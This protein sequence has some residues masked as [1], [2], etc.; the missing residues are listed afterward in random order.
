MSQ[1]YQDLQPD[2][3]EITAGKVAEVADLIRAT[4]GNAGSAKDVK[5]APSDSLFSPETVSVWVNGLW[6]TS[7][8]LSLTTALLAV[9][10]K[11]WIHQYMAVPSGTP[12]DR[13]RIRQLRFMNLQTWHVPVIISLLPVLMHVALGVFF[14]GLIV[15]L[16]S[17]HS[18]ICAIV[19]TIASIG[20]TAY[21]G[22]TILPLFDPDCPYKTPL[23]MYAHALWVT[24]R[25]K[26][27]HAEKNP[28]MHFEYSDQESV[29]SPTASL[30]DIE[31]AKVTREPGELDA[32]CLSWLY[33]A[34]S[35]S[36][37]QRVVMA[38]YG[39]LPLLYTAMVDANIP[40]LGDAIAQAIRLSTLR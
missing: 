32:Q 3:N 31:K 17:L 9:L 37:V 28:T 34:S 25:S 12:R 40:N 24:C 21:F 39:R 38:A 33:N 27:V 23:T 35:N 22:T 13:S 7:L 36:S 30:V 16:K 26:F 1:T 11:Q 29:L 14:I 5:H 10:T 4:H 20:F 2:Y 6:F 8:A 18:T 19:G 15:L